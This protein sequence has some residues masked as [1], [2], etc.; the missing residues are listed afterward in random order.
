MARIP[1]FK[2][3]TMKRL[4]KV[5]PR[6]FDPSFEYFGG[7]ANSFSVLSLSWVGNKICNEGDNAYQPHFDDNHENILPFIAMPELPNFDVRDNYSPRSGSDSQAPTFMENLPHYN[8]PG[9]PSEVDSFFPYQVSETAYSDCDNSSATSIQSFEA[10]QSAL[11]NRTSPGNVRGPSQ[12][13]P[14]QP[15]LPVIPLDLSSPPVP[16]LRCPAAGQHRLVVES[17]KM[18]R[19]TFCTRGFSLKEDC[20]QE[21][22]YYCSNKTRHRRNISVV[23]KSPNH[24]DF[25]ADS[26]QSY[27]KWSEKE[28]NWWHKDLETKSVIWAPL[29]FD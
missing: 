18:E 10:N 8:Y 2:S 17:Q 27:W 1:D 13:D 22:S 29:D 14:L 12:V 11:L 15:L 23:S 3:F 7:L 4:N 9:S 19:M 6:D 16:W 26:A 5:Q 20:G 28:G 24:K 21:T 25:M